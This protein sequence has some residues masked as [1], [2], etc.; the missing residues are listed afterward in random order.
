[1]ILNAGLYC[2]L[3]CPPLKTDLVDII[4]YPP[5][6]VVKKIVLVETKEPLG[7]NKVQLRLLLHVIVEVVF[8]QLQIQGLAVNAQ[9]L[10]RL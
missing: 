2:A 8:S 10:T 7:S 3:I 9:R 1:M 4:Q 6:E 5:P